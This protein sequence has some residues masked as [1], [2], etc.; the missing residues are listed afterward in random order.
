MS[1]QK[2]TPWFPANIN[3]T[4]PGIYECNR[5]EAGSRRV[6]RM[7]LWT[8]PPPMKGWIYTDDGKSDKWST[9]GSPAAMISSDG[10]KWRGIQGSE[11]DVQRGESFYEVEFSDDDGAGKYAGCDD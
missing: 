1:K 4:R 5:L 2:K 7:L 11:Y 8:G 6:T 9:P 10:D 3:P